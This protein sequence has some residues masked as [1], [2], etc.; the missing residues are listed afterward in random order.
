VSPSAPIRSTPA[1][2]R[3]VPPEVLHAL[4]NKPPTEQQWAAI[5]APLEPTV[6]IAGAGSGKTAVMAA[7]IVWL[8]LGGHAKPSE[9]LGLTFTNKAADNL[10]QRVRTAVEPLGL[11]DGEEPVI[12][13]YHG[14]AASLIADYGLRAGLEPGAALMS[15]AQA[16]QLCAELFSNRTYDHLVVRSLYH[17]SSVQHLADECAN[18]LVSPRDVIEH[19]HRFLRMIEEKGIKVAY[20]VRN[21]SRYRIELAGVVEDYQRIKRDRQ[22]LDY[23]DQIAI[24]HE[25]AGDE[26]VREDFLARF[27]VSL[28]DEFQDTNHAQAQLLRRLMPPGYPVMAVGDPDQNI[29]AWRG[30]SLANL[31]RFPAEFTTRDGTPA[32]SMPL[33]VN[34]R[35]GS[36]IL[37]LA[38]ALIDEI[39]AARRPPGKV[40]EPYER[41]GVG[42]VLALCV[43]DQLTEAERIA[44]Q[45]IAAHEAGTPWREIAILPRK[46]RLFDV[47]VE[48]FRAREIPLEVIGLGGLLRMPEV[49]DV[50]AV[51]RVLNDPM[52][53]VALARLLRGPRWRIGHRD[54][55]MIARHAADRN[56]HLRE[57]LTDAETPGDVAFSLAEALGSLV[58]VEGLSDEA[59][60]RLDVFNADLAA[61][62]AEI[63]A[64]PLEELVARALDW[65]GLPAELAASA[66]PAASS[67]ERNLANFLDRVAAFEPLDGEPTLGTLIEWLD[68]IESSDEEIEASQPTEH[69]SVKLMTIHQAK[70]LEFD[71]VFIPGL[72]AGKGSAKIFPDT[73]RQPNPAENARY[74]PFE[75]R[76]DRDVLPDWD[77]N[78]AGFKRELTHRAMEEERRLLYVAVTRARKR[79]IASAAH[80]YEP[81][82]MGEALKYP[83]GPSEFWHEIARFEQTQVL[84][85]V[86][87]APQ[88][89]PLIARRAERAAVWPQ[90][91][92]RGQPD[93]LFPQ[94]L[95]AA[96]AARRAQ[97]T[98]DTGLFPMDEPAAGSAIPT[99][100]PVSA[101]VTYKGCPLRFA[102]SYVRPLPRRS[103]VAARIGT[104]VHAWIEQ[105][106][107][108]QITLYDPDEFEEVEPSREN[109]RI[110]EL[111]AT[112]KASRFAG[113]PPVASERP[114]S[115][116]I[117]DFAIHGRIDAIFDRPGGGWEI[118]DFKTGR[119]PD[120]PGSAAL[121]LDLY[122]LAAQEIWGKTA[123][124]ITLTFA[125]FG[126][127]EE[128]SFV[129]RPAEQLRGEV[130][131]LLDAI[132]AN[133]FEP[134]PSAACSHCDFLRD[135]AA[136]K[137]FVGP[138]S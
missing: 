40:L 54:L 9:I 45:A 116:L 85:R 138:A 11:P 124:E 36:R 14:F 71:V 63:A 105:H 44:D 115:L 50:V 137:E 84:E 6:L 111:K 64:L 12:A 16:W 65:L 125:Y 33:F 101:L 28:L 19:D 112:F 2:A 43:D 128:R 49:I 1:F 30:A 56:R 117:G 47:L 132:A 104:K 76:G 70:G 25:L 90:P 126:S 80:W 10:L 127:S 75:F 83:M 69:D 27:K 17:V 86:D 55:A 109:E 103:S 108:G 38:N 99:S 81:S 110:A 8:I 98:P 89:N 129:A 59:R 123:E 7:R 22:L 102:W 122:A 120:E 5:A 93:P 97:V 48:V 62:R 41:N 53:N 34:F 52:R 121:Q 51:L 46:K 131:A 15:E 24:A 134:E 72:A 66:S 32:A 78:L 130:A 100:L 133:A 3:D 106:G 119:A 13:T 118:V 74:L 58:E 113:L 20:K 88:P 37:A 60:A 136:G 87:E 35:S 39:P 42:E 79:L 107:R 135:C 114:F 18:H 61:L 67:I 26:A 95:A 21:S 94:G 31:L 23:G 57:A 96:V 4:G 91:A 82:G 29:Y 73:G 68:A 77:N 92:H